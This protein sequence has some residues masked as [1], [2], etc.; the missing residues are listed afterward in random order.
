ML[1]DFFFG[2]AFELFIEDLALLNGQLSF[3]H[4]IVDQVFSASPVVATAPTPAKNIFLIPSV[5]SILLFPFFKKEGLF[6]DT[7]SITYCQKIS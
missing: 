5:M 1:I 6:C 4:Q 3:F 7:H 2:I